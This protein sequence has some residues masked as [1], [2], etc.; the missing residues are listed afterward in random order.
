MKKLFLAAIL[1][2]SSHAS[3]FYFSETCCCNWSGSLDIGGGYRQDHFNWDTLLPISPQT[4]IKEQWNDVS[5]G[6]IEANGQLYFEEAFLLADF[7]YGWI[8]GGTHRLRNIDIVTDQTIQNFSSKTKGDVWDIS[9]AIGYQFDFCKRRYFLAPMLGC[10][11]HQQALKNHNYHDHLLDRTLA[12]TSRFSYR[13]WGPWVGFALGYQWTCDWQVYLDYRFHW[14]RFRGKVNQDIGIIVHNQ[15]TRCHL[16]NEV[17]LGVNY[18]F[19]DSW[20]AGL[21]VNYKNLNTNKNNGRHYSPASHSNA[22]L[23]NLRWESYTV[24]MDVG[25]AF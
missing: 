8:C 11:Y 16:E 13:F 15:K 21:K 22:S 3:A 14:I 6:V 23:R 12:A 10:S 18:T 1:A 19:C 5:I 4:K 2:F 25:Y 9:G 20:W 17:T 24:S 7:S